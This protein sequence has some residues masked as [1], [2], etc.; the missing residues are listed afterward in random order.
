MN[1]RRGVLYVASGDFSYLMHAACSILSLRDNGYDGPISILTD[2]KP[3]QLRGLKKYDVQCIPVEIPKNARRPSRWI[4]TQLASFSPY[5]QTL[6]IDADT[7]ILRPI[8]GIRRFLSKGP[9]C[10]AMDRNQ[11]LATVNHGRHEEFL[12]TIRRHPTTVPHYNTGILLWRKSKKADKLFEEWHNEWLRFGDIDQLAFIRAVQNTG[13]K[14]AKLPLK[15][16]YP[17][18]CAPDMDSAL[19][20]SVVIWHFCE[21]K[22][23]IRKCCPALYKRALKMTGQHNWLSWFK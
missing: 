1:E 3:A 23:K 4:K 21:F 6:A 9:V 22:D 8:D 12:Y 11:T 14:P 15:F 17:Q 16:N 2:F 10:A 13:I 19:R 18:L 7:V 20:K 5:K